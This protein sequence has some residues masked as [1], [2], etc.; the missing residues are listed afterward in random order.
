MHQYN[1]LFSFYN[2]LYFPLSQPLMWQ[3]WGKLTAIIMAAKVEL[4]IAETCKIKQSFTSSFRSKVCKNC[5]NRIFC[6]VSIINCAFHSASHSCGSDE[7]SLQPS[8]WPPK[9]SSIL[10]KLAKCSPA[11]HAPLGVRYVRIAPI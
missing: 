5:A 9:L 1:F 4:Y 2:K 10:Q 7:G 3:W 6:L 11:L 8:L